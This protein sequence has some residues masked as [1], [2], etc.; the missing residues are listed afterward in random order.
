M[1]CNNLPGNGRNRQE[2]GSPP[3][4]SSKTPELADY[5]RQNVVFPNCMVDRITPVTQ[6]ADI[7]DLAERFG[8]ADA[9][10]VV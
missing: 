2:D 5:L 3:S 10:P 9:W 8:V 4:P 1:S 6:Q 7:D